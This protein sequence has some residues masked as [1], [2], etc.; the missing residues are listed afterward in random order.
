MLRFKIIQ[1]G[2]PASDVDLSSAY[3][4][5][6][7]RVPIRAE[8]KYAKGEVI[9]ESRTRGAAAMAI[10]WPVEG[11]GRVMMETP[12]LSE[13]HAPYN[14]H[15]ELAR[16]QLMR[17]SQKREDWGLY[18]FEEGRELYDRVDAA[19]KLLISAITAPDDAS[20]ASFADRAI[21]ESVSVGE[22]LA[23]FHADVFLERRQAAN[24]L[25]KRVFGCRIDPAKN[26][27]AY[28]Q[29]LARGFDFGLLPLPWRDLEPKEGE[30]KPAAAEPWLNVLRQQKMAVWAESL[31]TLDPAQLP[32]WLTKA[33]RNYEQF[34]DAVTRHIRQ[35]LR[36]YGPYVH[37]WEAI[38]GAHAHNEF[39]FTFEQI[40]E[41]TR[42]TSLLIKQTSPRSSSIIGITQPWGEYYAT[43]PRTIPP[44]LYAEM[45]VSSGVHFDAFGIDL[46][47]CVDAPNTNIY[48]RDTMQISSMLDRFGALGKPIHVMLAGVPSGGASGAAGCWR[49][50]WSDNVQSDWFNRVFRIALS[51]PFVESV[52]CHR[53]ADAGSLDGILNLD[54]TPKPAYREIL[55]L[56]SELTD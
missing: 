53:L 3:L 12:R 4:V 2:K 31:L 22:D 18:D 1:D 17:I 49:E 48:M 34:R 29:H 43:D 28:K 30:S 44:L 39:R 5:G 40:M 11:V 13:R 27:D 46:R 35:M 23:K 51:K 42:I 16:G 50:Q 24:Q 32:D 26:S 38:R 47:F 20:A 21:T 45:A 6:N 54:C 8:I 19:R 55:K 33:A 41:L 9:A 7:D 56:K 14:L 37:V 10:L 52:C 15:L 25:T 36:K